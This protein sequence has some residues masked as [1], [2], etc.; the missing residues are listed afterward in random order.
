MDLDGTRQEGGSLE[1][2]EKNSQIEAS[3]L[4][5]TDD[6]INAWDPESHDQV[7]E[8]ISG[9]ALYA[10]QIEVNTAERSSQSRMGN[11]YST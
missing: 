3:T 11:L 7:L 1:L 6:D 5:R 9:A 8:V 2:N 10:R 4:L